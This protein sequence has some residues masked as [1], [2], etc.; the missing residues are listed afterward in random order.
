[1][2]IYNMEREKKFLAAIENEVMMSEQEMAAFFKQ[3]EAV[4]GYVVMAD[5]R[6]MPI[7]NR[8]VFPKRWMDAGCMHNFVGE[9]QKGEYYA[10]Q[11]V[12]TSKE[13]VEDMCICTKGFAG[14]KLDCIN[15]D[16][17]D[18]YGKPFTKKLSVIADKIQPLWFGIQIPMDCEESE[19]HGVITV[20]PQGKPATEINV[21]LIIGSEVLE[22]CGDSEPWRHSRLRWLNSDVAVDDGITHPFTPLRLKNKSIKGLGHQLKLNCLGLPSAVQSFF[23][24]TNES[25]K[26]LP[27]DII[28]GDFTFDICADGLE[29]KDVKPV[30]FTK[31]V[32]GVVCWESKW[33][34]GDSIE[35]VCTAK[36][37]FDGY[38]EYDIAVTG[39]RETAIND[40]ALK[41]PYKKEAAKYWM[42]MGEMGGYRKSDL[43]WKWEQK[44]NQDTMWMGEVN[45]GMMVRLKDESYVKPMMLIYYHYYPLNMPKSWDNGGAGG[46]KVTEQGDKVMLEA[47]SGKRTLKVGE[48]LHY[49]FDLSI[50]PVKPIDKVEHWQDHYFHN[51]PSDLRR[52][53]RC[54]ANIIN[55]HHA[56]DLNP[57]INYPFWETEDLMNYVDKAHDS[58][59]RVKIY[60]T[61]KEITVRQVEF[62]A[63]M[64]LNGEIIPTT[65]EVGKSFQ[66]D[67]D[68][69]DEWFAKYLGKDFMTAWRQRIKK[70]KYV[71]EMEASVVCAPMSRFN[72]YF[73][74]GVKWILENTGMDG[75][76]F[77]DVAFNREI[78][79]RCR[80][81]LDRDHPKCTIDLHS[82]NYYKNNNVDNSELAGWGNSMNLY[83]DNF[84]FIDRLW[85]GE[86]FDYNVAPD[87]WLIEISGIPFGMM[88][89]MLQFGGNVWRGMVYGMSNRLPQP[90][91]TDP[92]DL[93]NLWNDFRMW[94]STMVGHW[95]SACPVDTGIESVKATVYK[96]PHKAMIV[97]AS[98]SDKDENVTFKIDFD[99]L[100]IDKS[101]V[102][103]EIPA[104]KGFQDS[105]AFALDKPLTI[106]AGK[107]W[108]ILLHE[109]A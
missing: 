38:I 47:Y 23:N 39:L 59:M 74:E 21:K 75:L 69:A 20:K 42:G 70:E 10:F 82:W 76:Y 60:D 98:W 44:L 109:E 9:P 65:Y 49:M 32:D 87:N 80:K 14:L 81:V 88:G 104:I 95:N 34:M 79:K 5:S 72:N 25:L 93:W 50:T 37:E 62:W 26:L 105:S 45:A 90:E 43:D 15:R 52:V 64:S 17:V 78:M 107:G 101:K 2:K 48:T 13:D 54:G 30:V 24:E 12:A 71:D 84:A 36:M 100:G 22:D 63:M 3:Y 85:F 103:V 11:I 86:G 73:L 6:E 51:D 29:K 91:E 41:I 56:T 102:K 18:S 35:V 31:V 57:Y 99:A 66:G 33:R 67:V 83:I 28:G 4:E 68:Y 16:G 40:I 61:V 46:C 89:E 8:K 106:P 77:D 53:S 92:T 7:H 96:Q 1:M 58:S 94:N 27:T 19:I 97:A 108:L 55:L